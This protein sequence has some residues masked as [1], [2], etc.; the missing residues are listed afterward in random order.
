MSKR[1]S[2]G[3]FGGIAGS[4]IFGMFG[5]VIRCDADDGSW[6]C[7]IMKLFNLLIVVLFVLYILYISYFLYSSFRKSFRMMR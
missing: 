4:G 6:Y 3:N 7:E 1:G 2:G 5:T